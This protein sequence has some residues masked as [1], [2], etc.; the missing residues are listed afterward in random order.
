[1][2]DMQTA[3]SRIINDWEK[4]ITMQTEQTTKQD[5]RVTTGVSQTTFDYVKN[6]PG[7]TK[8]VVI[9]EL[10]AKGFK[11][12]STTTLLSAM[13][14]Q[15]KIIVDINGGLR[16]AA[17]KYTPVK[18]IPAKRKQMAAPRQKPVEHVAPSQGLAALYVPPT[19]ETTKPTALTAQ[20]VLDTLNVKEAYDLYL[21]LAKMFA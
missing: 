15:K 13:I 7:K 8:A 17:D 10:D 2:A 1:M 9:S 5:K 16:A 21:A 11:P 12:A 3:I 19:R 20:D 4:E 14:R 18:S 6:N